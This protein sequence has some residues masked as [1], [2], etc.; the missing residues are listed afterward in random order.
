M[1][2]QSRQNSY[3]PGG[4]QYR[5][6]YNGMEQDEEVSGSGNSY[7]TEFR[8]YDPRLGRWKSLDPLM[9]KFP[10]QSPYCAFDDNPIYFIDPYGLSA[11]NGGDDDKRKM[12][13]KSSKVKGKT[14]VPEKTLDLEEVTISAKKVDQTEQLGLND[15]DQDGYYLMENG[16]W[17]PAGPMETGAM[18]GGEAYLFIMMEQ[19]VVASII[20]KQLRGDMAV[21]QGRLDRARNEQLEW[22]MNKLNSPI[23]LLYE[24]SPLSSGVHAT[25]AVEE[26][27]V[28][29]AAGILI[30]ETAPYTKVGKKVT[31]VI[32]RATRSNK[33]NPYRHVK[34]NGLKST[35]KV[36]F[37]ALSASD[38]QHYFSNIV[39]NYMA[40]AY[41]SSLKGGDGVYRSF[42]QVS[43]SLN[44]AD[45]VFEWIVETGGLVTHRRFI[46][47]GRI[48]GT[49]N[50][51]PN[52]G[53]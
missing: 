12:R 21:A 22:E 50:Q 40:T 8:Q 42:Y 20:D 9:A 15:I 4:E 28:G 30:L 26:G 35:E 11:T 48:T 16:D 37:K 36:A 25:I 49:P 6:A 44:G 33:T 5:Y 34:Y 23:G 45:G 29:T 10:W 53:R 27:D 14:N 13:G 7:T 52:F 18:P 17:R 46:P 3:A 32:R 19:R 1:T 2:M 51:I 43:G 31:N 38:A 24:A 39:D 41:S 47:G